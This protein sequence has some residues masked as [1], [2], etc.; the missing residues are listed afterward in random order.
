MKS[1]EREY[2]NTKI[3]TAVKLFSNSDP[4]MAAVRCFKAKAVQ[5]W[6]H[7]I[8]KGAQKYAQELGLQLQLDFPDL[9]CYTA[10]GHNAIQYN[11]IRYNTLFMHV[12]PRSS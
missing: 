10:D 1:V 6:R 4:A 3:K 7:S 2:K 12:R 11:K 5:T 8:I 9:V